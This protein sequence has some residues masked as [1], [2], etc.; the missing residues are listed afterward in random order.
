LL[1]MR[2]GRLEA[3]GPKEVVLKQALQPVAAPVRLA[4]RVQ[5]AAS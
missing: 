3:F 5:A 4:A 1:V 2:A